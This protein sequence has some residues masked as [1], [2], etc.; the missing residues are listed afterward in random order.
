MG[1]LYLLSE[2]GLT[3]FFFVSHPRKETKA[4]HHVGQTGRTGK[5]E[6]RGPGEVGGDNRRKQEKE[7]FHDSGEEEKTEAPFEEKCRRGFEEGAG[8]EGQAAARDDREEVRKAEE[9]GGTRRER[10]EVAVPR[11]PGQNLQNRE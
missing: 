4:V 6:G 1:V 5:E 2:R 8:G 3:C 9:S 10:T 7:G 11:L